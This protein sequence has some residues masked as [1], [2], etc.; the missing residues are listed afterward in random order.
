M[1]QFK[2]DGLYGQDISKLVLY[3]HIPQRWPNWKVS[4][5]DHQVN[6]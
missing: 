5:S 6:K 1:K 3:H 4:V 2:K